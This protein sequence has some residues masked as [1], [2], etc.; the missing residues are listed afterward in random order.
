MILANSF[1]KQWFPF[2]SYFDVFCTVCLTFC[3]IV[4]P[5]GEKYVSTFSD[6]AAAAARI[7]HLLGF[8]ELE[9]QLS[10]ET[11]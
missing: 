2:K 10:A 8:G 4:L 1:V 11:T 9:P 5:S 7:E 3:E 6:S